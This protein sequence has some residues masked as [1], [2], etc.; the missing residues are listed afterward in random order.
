MMEALAECPAGVKIRAL[1]DVDNPF[2]G[3]SG[4]AKVFGPQKGAGPAEVELLEERMSGQAAAILARTGVDVSRMKGA[5]AAGG[6]GGALAAC[7]G[8]EL[9][10]GVDAVLDLVRFSR[11]A[12]GADLIITGE[13]TSDIQTLSGKVPMGVLRRSGGI[14]VVL[15][16]GRIRDAKALLAAGFSR[17][18]PATPPDQPL[19]EA[20]Q[21]KVAMENLRRAAYSALGSS[22]T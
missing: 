22:L 7:Y 10:S 18:I 13:G 9:R 5:G 16:S 11:A 15:L 20:L 12:A 14:P 1:C 2:L 3:P 8:A 21:P 19:S 17:L 4:A 6:L